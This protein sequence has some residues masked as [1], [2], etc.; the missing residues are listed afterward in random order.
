MKTTWTLRL[1]TSFRELFPVRTSLSAFGAKRPP[2]SVKRVAADIESAR[3]AL[4]LKRG[5]LT[6][7]MKKRLDVQAKN[8]AL[9]S[10]INRLEAKNHAFNQEKARL[11][12]KIER[13]AELSK[14]LKVKQ[15]ALCLKEKELEIANS[16]I[17][18]LSKRFNN[19]KAHE[20]RSAATQL[21]MQK[22]SKEIEQKRKT[23]YIR[24]KM[25]SLFVP[26]YFLKQEG[27]LK[28]QKSFVQKE[29][30]SF[31]GFLGSASRA[32]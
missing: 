32:A 7:E 23:S 14:T 16:E 24:K 19:K 3:S 20:K 2:L 9:K 27:G 25:H 1:R 30:S 4:E 31:F 26:S 28:T 6:Q 5:E 13:S 11:L 18:R 8:Y 29:K 10:E 15:R 21:A 22:R 12:R 17:L